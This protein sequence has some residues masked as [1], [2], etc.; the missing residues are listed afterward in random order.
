MYSVTIKMVL[1]FHTSHVHNSASCATRLCIGSNWCRPSQ[2]AAVFCHD[3]VYSQCETRRSTN[4]GA[5]WRLC[6]AGSS[7]WRHCQTGCLL[8]RHCQG[9]FLLWL[10][11]PL[12][13]RCLLKAV[14]S[15]SVAC[16]VAAFR[17]WRSF[18][19]HVQ[20]ME[21]VCID[22]DLAATIRRRRHPCSSCTCSVVT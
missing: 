19:Q 9:G 18:Y 13:Q 4:G 21:L 6:Q 2:S 8:W 10:D 5:L 17:D 15:T 14:G 22:W 11:W 16:S 7:R 1:H 20:Y 12:V 3:G